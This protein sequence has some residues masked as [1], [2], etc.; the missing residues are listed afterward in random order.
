[1]AKAV[2]TVCEIREILGI[3]KNQAYKLCKS[4]EFPIRR[5]G[6]TILIPKEPFDRWLIGED[7]AVVN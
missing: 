5:V 2:Y 7:V 4:K 3:G 6:N 1:M